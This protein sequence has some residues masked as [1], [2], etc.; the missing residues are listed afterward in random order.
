M[1]D[2]AFEHFTNLADAQFSL[3]IEFARRQV[4]AAGLISRNTRVEMQEAD[5][6]PGA[7]EHQALIDYNTR[8]P[9]REIRFALKLVQVLKGLPACV[10]NFVLCLLAI[11]EDARGQ[12]HAFLVVAQN[13]L[14]E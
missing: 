9:D 4:N 2:L 14:A 10:L 5:A 3:R 13:Q 8:Q 6:A 7:H 12:A 11:P 1:A